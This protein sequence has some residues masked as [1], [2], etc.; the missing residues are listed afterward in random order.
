MLKKKWLPDNKQLYWKVFRQ[1]LGLSI[2]WSEV[3]KKEK[4]TEKTIH[5]CKGGFLLFISG[6]QQKAFY[7][8]KIN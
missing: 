4:K 1:V 7:N 8:D 6:I 3:I 2:H 5:L